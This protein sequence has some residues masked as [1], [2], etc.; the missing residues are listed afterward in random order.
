MKRVQTALKDVIDSGVPVT[1]GIWRT[2]S[3]DQ[4]PPPQYV[5]YSTTMS[6]EGHSDDAP[7]YYKT[8]VYMELWSKIDPTETKLAIRKQM[9]AA[10]FATQSESDRGYGQPAYDHFT[11][12]YCVA[13]IFHLFEEEAE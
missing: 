5:V 3:S 1:R 6:E 13:W 7:D 4:N 8:I 9:N 10:G 2:D 12:N 11:H